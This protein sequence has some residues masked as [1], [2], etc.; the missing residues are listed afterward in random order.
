MRRAAVVAAVVRRGGRILVTRR[1]P[2]GPRGGLW[3]FPGGKVE[4]G[5]SEPAALRRELAEELGCDVAVGGLLFRHSHE[6]PDLHVDLAF[7]EC[8][9]AP[10]AEPRCVGV[11][12]VEWAEPAALGAYEFCPADVAVLPRIAAGR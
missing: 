11:S 5:E 1:P 8:A 4:P 10:G 3:E 12:A 6:Y 2:G 9:I 7:Y